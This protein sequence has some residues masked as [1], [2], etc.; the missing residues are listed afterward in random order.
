M[1]VT[2]KTGGNVNIIIPLLFGELYMSNLIKEFMD[3][4]KIG[5]LVKV[6]ELVKENPELIYLKD[7]D[8]TSALHYASGR[9]HDKIVRFLLR[10]GVYPSIEGSGGWTP[11]HWAANFGRLEVTKVLLEKGAETNI[12]NIW[13]QT[14]LY[15]AASL[16]RREITELLIANG[17]KVNISSEDGQTP[18][19]RASMNG[20]GEVV[21]LLIEKG[22]DIVSRDMGGNTPLLL[23]A[24]M[25]QREIVELLILKGAY[26][27]TRDIS[28]KTPLHIAS[29][30]GDKEIVELLLDRGSKINAIDDY[31]YTPLTYA[32]KHGH[33]DVAELLVTRGAEPKIIEENYGYSPYIKRRLGVKEAFIWYLFHC[34]WA[35]KTRSKLLIFD[36]WN[37]GKNPAYPSLAN[38]HIDSLEIKDLDVAVFI[39]HGHGDHYDKT[40]FEWE[41]EIENLTYV[42]GWQAKEGPNYIRME[43]REKKNIG[44]MEILTIKA[45]HGEDGGVGFLIKIDDLRIYHSG[46]HFNF[47]EELVL[48]FTS[49]IDYI[50]EN[51]KALDLA[52]INGPHQVKANGIYYALEKLSPKVMFMM[53]AGGK[54]YMHFEFIKKAA[55]KHFKT[56]I[57]CAWNRGDRFFYKNNNIS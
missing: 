44:E 53:H 21:K 52:F 51:M 47:G 29:I 18:L 36:Y 33:R 38:G 57:I 42:F 31:G 25:N 19:H 32:S 54:E 34:G 48:P 50:A 14:P 49:E 17:A 30:A 15:F 24:R 7:R 56:K 20:R 35:I 10:R 4:V 39:T 3:A 13:G 23:A 40:I 43:G 28:G 45:N 26:L 6:T 1:L 2:V 55:K 11:L 46:D 12:Q 9:G 16:G 22:A 8:E 5:D 27:D 37:R 41:H